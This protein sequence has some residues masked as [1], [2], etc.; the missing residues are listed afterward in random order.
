M[1]PSGGQSRFLQFQSN[2]CVCP[3][4]TD[5]IAPAAPTEE[6]FTVEYNDFVQEAKQEGKL[7]NVESV[8]EVQ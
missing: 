5:P 4:D 3:V 2:T 8:D 6:E 1:D 7:T